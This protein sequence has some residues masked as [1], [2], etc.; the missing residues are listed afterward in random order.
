MTGPQCLLLLYY[1]CLFFLNFGPHWRL[2]KHGYLF[3]ITKNVHFCFKNKISTPKISCWGKNLNL[4]WFLLEVNMNILRVLYCTLEPV[5]RS[6]LMFLDSLYGGGGERWERSWKGY[7]PLGMPQTD[8]ANI[9][10]PPV[11]VPAVFPLCAPGLPPCEHPVILPPRPLISL[12][13]C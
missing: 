11:T 2:D 12:F 9:S 6:F 3:L 10:L 5:Y 1:T 7:R 8:H 4:C 13:K